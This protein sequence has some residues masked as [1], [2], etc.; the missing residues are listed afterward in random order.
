MIV[1]DEILRRLRAVGVF[2]DKA[3]VSPEVIHPD[4]GPVCRFD[5]LFTSLDFYD[6]V[7][8]LRAVEFM[9]RSEDPEVSGDIVVIPSISGVDREPFVVPVGAEWQ[10]RV[11][12]LFADV[13][14]LSLRIDTSDPRYTLTDGVNII[15]AYLRCIKT[16]EDA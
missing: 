13:G 9:T 7:D 14:E 16:W 15:T 8:R 11:I 2:P 6:P 5:E 1:Y 4:Y 12:C 3:I 10:R